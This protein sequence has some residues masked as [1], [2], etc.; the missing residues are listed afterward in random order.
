M[1]T[2]GGGQEVGG[3][4]APGRGGAG[5]AGEGSG[6][7]AAMGEP[8]LHLLQDEMWPP[9]RSGAGSAVPLGDQHRRLRWGSPRTQSSRCR[10]PW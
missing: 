1:R 6:R 10:C 5:G 9:D 7:R 8:G 3:K 4:S 2:A